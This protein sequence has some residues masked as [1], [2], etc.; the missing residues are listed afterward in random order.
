MQR[1]RNTFSIQFY[2][3]R[4]KAD[5]KGLSP[6]EAAVNL[7]GERFFYHLPI[8]ARPKDFL[9]TQ[10]EYLYS[11]EKRLRS[12]E[13]EC[14]SEGEALTVQG[15][16]DYIRN[17]YSSPGKKIG[18]MYSAF[19]KHLERKV[20]AGQ[21]AFSGLRK[22]IFACEHFLG[23]L[24]REKPAASITPGYV[25]EF[26]MMMSRKYQNSTCAG[27]LTKVKSFL[28]YGVMNGFMSVSPWQYR[29]S[30]KTKRVIIPTM[31]EYNRILELDL[32]WNKSLERARDLWAFASGSGLAYCDIATLKGKDVMEKDGIHY[33]SKTRGKT[34]TEFFAVLLPPALAV[35]TKHQEDIPTII[36]NQKINAYL[37]VIGDLAGCSVPLHFH[38]AR[39]IYCHILLNHYHLDYAIAA[40][41][42][43]HKHVAVTQGY[44]QIW[45]E[46]ILQA[47]K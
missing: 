9:K 10:G 12:Y 41:M 31:T 14:L 19:I 29:I 21:L 3:R 22:Y 42:L 37:K 16:K 34:G 8:K 1:F 7:N 30:K 18:T 17:G 40:K 46:T 20:D 4:S 38:L 15:L 26:C 45:N 27:M 11:V 36:S 6:V 39:H 23:G 5:K 43:G 13:M 24:D 25:E 44:G 2:C 33:I 47:F 32:S 28:S 35:Y